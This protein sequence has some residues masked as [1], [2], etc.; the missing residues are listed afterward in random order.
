MMH[1]S[2]F[3]IYFRIED[4]G[5]VVLGVRHFAADGDSRLEERL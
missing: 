2:K 5:V 1:H 4:I 3:K